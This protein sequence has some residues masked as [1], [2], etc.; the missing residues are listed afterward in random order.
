MTDR[1]TGLPAAADG[2]ETA[3]PMM[4]LR[5]PRVG[6]WQRLS[7][8]WLIPIAALVV[9]LGVA[10]QSYAGRG[11]LVRISFQNGAGLVAGQTVLKFRDVNVGVVE[12]VGFSS[13]LAEVIA[14]V[15][16]DKDVAPF[17]DQDAQFWIVRPEVSVRGITG[18]DTVLSGAFIAAQWDS[19]A[20]RAQ[21]SFTGLEAVPVNAQSDRGTSI[22]LKLRD[23]NQISAGAPILYKGIEVGNASTPRLSEDGTVVLIDAYIKD[24]YNKSLTTATRFWDASGFALSLGA[25]G[26][27]L[28]VKSLAS[29]IEG[30][31]SFD[32]VDSG[33]APVSGTT[34]FDVYDDEA[35]ARDSVFTGQNDHA[36]QVSAVFD[37]SV[38]G[39]SPG[40][41][42]RFRGLTVGTVTDL[43]A[44]VEGEG[45]DRR[46]R[47]LVNMELRT[48]KL[49]LGDEATAEDALALLGDFVQL[50]GLRARLATASLL[51]GGLLVEL[52][53]VPDAPEASIDV[54][55]QP[56]PRLPITAS[57]IADL[58]ATSQGVL[59]RINDLPVEE[60]MQSAIS[61][62]KNVDALASNPDTLRVPTEAAGL[63]ADARAL[64]TSEDVAAIPAE[65]RGIT[66]DLR[67]VLA[68]LEQGQAVENLIAAI[69]KAD[70]ALDSLATAS[71]DFPIITGQIRDLGDKANQ[72]EIEA[73]AASATR[74]LD[75]ANDLIGSEDAKR[76]PPALADALAEVATFLAEVRE[77]GAIANANSAISAAEAAA[78]SINEA[79][80]TLPALSERLNG[81]VGQAEGTLSSYG[82]RSRFNAKLL[83]T[84]SDLQG[85]ADSVSALARAI[86]RDPSSLL[87]GR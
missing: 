46:V 38:S 32:T 33:G 63:L 83:E 21:S 26:V 72:L 50:N 70:T 55:A 52:L 66:Q 19:V 62:L 59:E 2:T 53:E 56:H 42:V 31:I 44:F 13:G 58:R 23:G 4:P 74:L 71:T 77:G 36:L 49:G 15:R 40:S 1:E 10:W 8:V 6:W 68:K 39:L 25:G 9:S 34:V 84:L 85:A 28:D 65:V 29:L 82:D 69:A 51:T 35:S 20:G 47:L 87:L 5:P 67:A 30:G 3:A 54:A 11:D 64:V 45:R 7:I 75:T 18:L 86:Q 81:L 78:N 61:L 73:L 80:K 79:A 17:M 57:D 41:D 76:L 22:T 12:A 27:T 60:L 43:G 37:G 48:A 14:S 24:P 16:V